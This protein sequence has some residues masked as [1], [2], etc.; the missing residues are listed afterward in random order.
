MQWCHDIAEK[1]MQSGE[2]QKKTHLSNM[3]RGAFMRLGLFGHRICSQALASS[4]ICFLPRSKGVCLFQNPPPVNIDK[5]KAE[6]S[7]PAMATQLPRIPR[8]VT[9]LRKTKIAVMMITTYEHEKNFPFA[10]RWRKNVLR[11]RLAS[12]CCTLHETCF[13]E[14]KRG[15]IK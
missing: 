9:G 8:G 7:P 15:D 10:K 11:I 1:S 3:Q 13:V 4:R 6:K 2:T 12:W 5:R 14:K